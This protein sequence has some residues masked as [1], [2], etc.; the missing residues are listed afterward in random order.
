MLSWGDP[1]LWTLSDTSRQEAC[2]QAVHIPSNPAPWH[3]QPPLPAPPPPQP[4]PGTTG[5]ASR[6]ATPQA[7]WPARLWR[8]TTRSEYS[9][10]SV[11]FL[12]QCFSAGILPQYFF[13]RRWCSRCVREIL[14][15]T[16]LARRQQQQG[17][18]RQKLQSQQHKH[19]NYSTAASR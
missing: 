11:R 4:Q 8:A 7:R 3:L 1:Y 18:Q 14:T 17:Q 19:A 10:P 12:P 2:A 5:R 15:S 13:A 6:T 16:L 9:D